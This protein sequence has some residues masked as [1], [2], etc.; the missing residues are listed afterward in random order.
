[1]IVYYDDTTQ[2]R[3]RELS[4]LGDRGD[5]VAGIKR[6]EVANLPAEANNQKILML[7]D[8]QT[9][10]V[11]MRGSLI[12]EKQKTMAREKIIEVAYRAFSLIPSAQRDAAVNFLKNK[13]SEIKNAT[14]RDTVIE[15]IR[16]VEA[17]AKT[18]IDSL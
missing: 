7:F 2:E 5:P 9:S 18:I 6:S 10:T 16:Q 4:S 3:Y 11:V 14:S 15:A 1:M 12:T 13:L 17:Q 8:T